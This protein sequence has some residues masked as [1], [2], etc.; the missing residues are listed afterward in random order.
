MTDRKS[1][2]VQL[3]SPLLRSVHAQFPGQYER[4]HQRYHGRLMEIKSRRRP[5]LAELTGNQSQCNF[6]GTV[7]NRSGQV[8]SEFL[9]CPHCDK[10][11]RERTAIYALLHAIAQPNNKPPVFFQGAKI[12]RRYHLLECSPRVRGITSIIFQ[13]NLRSY[14]RS[15]FDQLSHIGDIRLDLTD[16]N[17]IA[18][19]NSKFD[20]I[21]CSHVLEHIPEYRKAL[22]GL[23]SLLTPGGVLILQVPL[24]EARY[25]AVTWDEFHADQ[26]RVFHRFAF[27]LIDELSRIFTKTELMVGLKDFKITSE[28]ISPRKYDLV[29]NGLDRVFEAGHKDMLHFGLGNPDLCDAFIAWN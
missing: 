26:T 3:I 15:D 28:E 24:L 23:K 12:L 25:T 20:I 4:L 21:L 29:H 19:Y 17:D 9:A 16:D 1:L 2:P 11:A 22:M 13:A 6:C 27:D 18:R 14:T 5:R 8:H 10:N 7:F